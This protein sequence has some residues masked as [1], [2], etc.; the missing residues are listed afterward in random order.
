VLPR[1]GP[2]LKVYIFFSLP[3]KLRTNKLDCFP[4]KT[5]QASLIFPGKAGANPSAYSRRSPLVVSSLTYSQKLISPEKYRRQLTVWLIHVRSFND[6]E[7]SY[8]T[9]TSG[10]HSLQGLF[11][12]SF[13]DIKLICL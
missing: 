10:K 6:E 3:L 4:V 13:S 9:L 7:K 1:L 12:T 2:G 11:R 5:F 8:L